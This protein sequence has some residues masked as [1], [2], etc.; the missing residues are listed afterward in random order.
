MDFQKVGY[1]VLFVLV[2]FILNLGLNWLGVDQRIGGF[3]GSVFSRFG[4]VGTDKN[5]LALALIQIL[6][7]I[8][9]IVHGWRKVT[10]GLENWTWM[11]SQMQNF[12]IGFGFVIWG[13]LA[14]YAEFGGGIALTLGWNVRFHS[15][16]LAGT[17]FVAMVYHIAQGDPWTKISFPLGLMVVFLGLMISGGEIGL[18]DFF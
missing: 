4:L 5:A 12:G 8:T 11:G 9:F 2:T 1:L 15:F 6:T 14:A 17:M 18:L 16:L 10:G 3:L 7:G 13:L